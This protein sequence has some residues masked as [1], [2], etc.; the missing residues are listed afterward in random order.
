MCHTLVHVQYR[1]HNKTTL[2]SAL[3]KRN[4]KNEYIHIRRRLSSQHT[5]CHARTS[6]DT[7]SYCGCCCCYCCW[8]GVGYISGVL[9]VFILYRHVGQVSCWGEGGG[10]EGVT[11]KERE[12]GSV[13][14]CVCVCVYGLY[15]Q[16]VLPLCT[17]H[18]I[19]IYTSTIWCHEINSSIYILEP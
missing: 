14:V 11:G 12:R 1:F 9:P 17:V 2:T 19:Y 4:Y 5:Q 18:N 8:V 16:I 7:D 3:S 15:Q 6:I 13:C 10:G